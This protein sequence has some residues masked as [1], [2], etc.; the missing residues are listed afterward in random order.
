MLIW[1]PFKAI[2]IKKKKKKEKNQKPSAKEVPQTQRPVYTHYVYIA[3]GLD[4]VKSGE[5]AMYLQKVLL[6]LTNTVLPVSIHPDRKSFIKN[7]IYFG[8][9]PLC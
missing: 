6:C 8:C 7:I 1:S 5:N 3:F 4:K 9:S 2:L